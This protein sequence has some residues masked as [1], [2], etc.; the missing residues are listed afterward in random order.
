MARIISSRKKYVQVKD[1]TVYPSKT[2][3]I[4]VLPD[5]GFSG[6]HKYRARMC[7]GFVNGKT[8]Y[9]DAT[10]TIQFVHKKEDGTVIPG[11]QNEQLV[12]IMIDRIKKLN[13]KFPCEQNAKQIAALQDCLDAC[14]ERID[15]RLERN[16]MGDLKE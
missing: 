12:L 6:A 1:L 5:D 7:A 16:V 8:K 13:E 3:T 11:W 4:E 14:Q 2:E 10:D 15:D 9:V